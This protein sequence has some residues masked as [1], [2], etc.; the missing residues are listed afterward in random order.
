MSQALQPLRGTRDLLPEECR[1]FRHVEN[2]A[3]KLAQLY[4]FEE[5]ETPMMEP[6]AVFKRSLGDTSDIVSKQMYAFKDLGGDEIVLRPEGTAGVARAFISEGLSQSLPLKLLYRGP[7]F[8]YERPQ[9]GR[10]R[11]FYQLGVEI[12]GVEKAQA[13]IEIILLASHILKEL[14]LNGEINTDLS[15]LKLLEQAGVRIRV[16]ASDVRLST[17]LD[18]I[19]TPLG[20]DFVVTNETV[21]ITNRQRAKGELQS[22]TYP[23][24]DLAMRVQ[25]GRNMI[26]AEAVNNLIETITATVSPE[27]WTDRDSPGSV[28]FYEKNAVLVVRQTANVQRDI[29][30]LLTRLRRE[31]K[32]PAAGRTA[33]PATSK[34]AE[35]VEEAPNEMP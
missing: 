18:Q 12:L 31:R 17:L 7:M 29:Q 20:L 10:Y 6:V 15:R 3:L 1:K 32:S 24:G 2:V 8:R 4:G 35:P 25:N 22:V 16:D 21:K 13:D 33:L 34:V 11:Q 30:A 19:V 27:S 23:I 5:I 9:K 28:K 26:D 14:K